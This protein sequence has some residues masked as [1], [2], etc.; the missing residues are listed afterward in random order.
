[1]PHFKRLLQ[2]D[3]RGM[4]FSLNFAGGGEKARA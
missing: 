1:M 3:R 2:A 4:A